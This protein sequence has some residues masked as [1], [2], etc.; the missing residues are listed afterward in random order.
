M[1]EK[2]TYSKYCE[3]AAIL[4]GKQIKAAR[5]RR[6]WSQTMLCE[7]AGISRVTLQRIETGD[8]R[9][10]IG[11]FFE[12]AVLV[13]IRL[14]QEDKRSLGDRISS[15]EDQITLLP[16]PSPISDKDFDDDF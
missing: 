7:R 14:F 3:E 8:L 9:T 1:A 5:L 4:L 10:A 15:L 13:G 12:V 6:S 2:R 16:K 11:L